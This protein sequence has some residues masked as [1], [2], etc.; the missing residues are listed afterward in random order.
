MYVQH[1]AK[2]IV[3]YAE[4]ATKIVAILWSIVTKMY[5]SKL[6]FATED[7]ATENIVILWSK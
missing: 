5:E 6:V 3:V 4:K 7:N 2:V 1:A